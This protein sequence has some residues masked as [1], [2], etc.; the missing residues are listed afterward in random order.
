MWSE[1]TNA[2][3]NSYTFNTFALAFL[4]KAS[5]AFLGT[6]ST[7]GTLISVVSLKHTEETKNKDP[8]NDQYL[9]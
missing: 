2:D 6:M 5:K 8:R 7:P 4:K 3:V 9:F 1:I